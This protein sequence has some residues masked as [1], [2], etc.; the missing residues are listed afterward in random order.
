M[1]SPEEDKA[2]ERR[3]PSVHEP[4]SPGPRRWGL[5]WAGEGDGGWE[6]GEG[7]GKKL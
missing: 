2:L 7:G 3:N 5:D 4:P 1:G 6:D